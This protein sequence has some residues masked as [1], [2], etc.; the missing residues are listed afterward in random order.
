MV[1]QRERMRER[2]EVISAELIIIRGERVR[3]TQA[4]VDKVF[5]IRKY[6]NSSCSH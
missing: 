2:R 3:Y 6:I 1:L 4:N 5:K